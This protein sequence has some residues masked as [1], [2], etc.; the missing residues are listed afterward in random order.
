MIKMT[1]KYEH[2]ITISVLVHSPAE[3][4]AVYAALAAGLGAASLDA[5]I[6][7]KEQISGSLQ[8]LNE[9]QAAPIELTTEDVPQST[10]TAKTT[11]PAE[12]AK[13]RKPRATKSTETP[14]TEEVPTSAPE[15][16]GEAENDDDEFAAFRDADGAGKPAEMISDADLSSACNDAASALGSPN[17]VKALIAQFVPEGEMVHSRNVPL[18]KRSDFVEQIKA[19]HK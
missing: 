11:S 15:T 4:A 10:V 1:E 16:T 7:R 19:L 2:P 3:T 9:V 17:Q 13:V 8:K 12:E 18:D 5:L 6:E 14:K